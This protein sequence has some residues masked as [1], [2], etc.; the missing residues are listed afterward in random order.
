LKIVISYI[1]AKNIPCRNWR[2]IVT[3]LQ[4]SWRPRGA[5]S[6]A[7]G[8]SNETG[9][10]V[11]LSVLHLKSP[12]ILPHFV[13]IFSLMLTTQS[14]SSKS[15]E[16]SKDEFSALLRRQAGG[17][18]DLVNTEILSG[19]ISKAKAFEHLQELSTEEY[20]HIRHQVVR[21]LGIFL[22]EPGY[23]RSQSY[24]IAAR[25]F[26]SGR[27]SHAEKEAFN[28][29]C[30]SDEGM[31]FF[32]EAIKIVKP[33]G[34]NFGN[35]ANAVVE[36][37]GE[38]SSPYIAQ[39]IKGLNNEE[40]GLE[41][42]E[43]KALA[44][45]GRHAV[46]GLIAEISSP[47]FSLDHCAASCVRNYPDLALPL[48]AKKVAIGTYEEKHEAI[49]QLGFCETI[50][51]VTKF[52]F[53]YLKEESVRLFN[54]TSGKPKGIESE[55][56]GGFSFRFRRKT[57]QKPEETI[58]SDAGEKISH[59]LYNIALTFDALS[60]LC[61]ASSPSNA[62]RYER[63]NTF[64]ENHFDYEKSKPNAETFAPF[65]EDDLSSDFLLR[66]YA[67]YT[68][69]LKEIEFTSDYFRDNGQ[70][71]ADLKS[72]SHQA[73]EA[74]KGILSEV[75]INSCNG[76]QLERLL[77]DGFQ[78]GRADKEILCALNK[79]CDSVRES[80]DFKNFAITQRGTLRQKHFDFEKSD[81]LDKETKSKLKKIEDWTVAD[82]KIALSI[83]EGK[84]SYL[85]SKI[86]SMIF[87]DTGFTH[88]YK[89][90]DFLLAKLSLTSHLEGCDSE[91]IDFALKAFRLSKEDF[92]RSSAIMV[93]SDK[94]E[95]KDF[96]NFLKDILENESLEHDTRFQVNHWLEKRILSESNQI[97][98]Q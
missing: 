5:A 46:E 43:K 98:S 61:S 89:G 96:W 37:F 44:K 8:I 73:S 92:V 20:S 11:G 13:V 6:P 7:P 39:L 95:K 72:R 51:E 14:P 29:L 45:L 21:S 65:L 53:N 69:A 90:A 24:L 83:H 27:F 79:A 66:T 68:K 31:I 54:L 16:I 87:S 50:P 25:I 22:D 93:L 18:E 48:I 41:L 64:S 62:G 81:D 28:L 82:L 34:R 3:V 49:R 55:S 1:G 4:C 47:K 80:I 74:V 60:L 76:T 26:A 70:I 57:I 10:V 71:D 36:K 67:E 85:T 15:K 2:R 38:K 23:F 97:E 30:S 42:E 12:W 19:R 78:S 17:A 63:K 77:V 59:T 52:L 75:L 40:R 86:P 58:T 56:S 84:Y 9:N 91:I 32:D 35:Y 94:M 33:A 88:D